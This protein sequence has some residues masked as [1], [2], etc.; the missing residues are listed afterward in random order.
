M[1]T[2]PEQSQGEWPFSR[3]AGA[4]H[5]SSCRRRGTTTAMRSKYTRLSVHQTRFHSRH[6]ERRSDHRTDCIRCVPKEHINVN[7]FSHV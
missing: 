7:W 6:T 3:A 2:R 4:S 5:S 1:A